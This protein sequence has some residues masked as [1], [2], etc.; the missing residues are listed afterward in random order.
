LHAFAIAVGLPDLPG[1]AL[2]A[3]VGEV[4]KQFGLD[5]ATAWAAG[6][7]SR[8]VLAAGV[9]HGSAAT[10]RRY[11][12]R[13]EQA[14]TLFD[15][16]PVEPSGRHV[17]HDAE[18]LAQG[19]DSWCADL[20]GQFCAAN[21]DLGRERVE[22]RLDTFGLMPIFSMRRGQGVLLSN[23]VQ[24]IR[25]LLDP[26]SLDALGVSTMLGLGWACD[27]HTLLEDVRVLAGGATYI[28]EPGRFQTRT[29][30]GPDAVDRQAGSRTTP[31][32]LTEFMARMIENAVG[33]VRPVHCAVTAGRDTR[34]LLAFMRSRGLDADFY[35]IGR[36]EDEDVLW[37]QE[38]GRRFGFEHRTIVPDQDTGLDWDSLAGD[39][40]AETDGLSNFGQLIDYTE[41]S[42]TPEQLGVKIWG[43]GSEIGRAGPGDTPIS[44]ANAPLLGSSLKLQRRI[45]EMKADGYRELMTAQ[46]QSILDRSIEEFAAQRLQEGW[47]VNEIAELFFT[48][49]RVACHGATGPRRAAAED[50][51]FSPFCSRRYAEYCLALKTTERYAELPYHQLL[52]RLSPE[53]YRYPFE[54]PL[55]SPRPWMTKPRAMERLTGVALKRFG[56]GTQGVDLQGGG[57]PPFVFEWFERSLDTMR[58]LFAQEQSPLWELI[59]RDRVLSLLG[60]SAEERYPHLEGL[61]R[62]ATVMWY[63]HGPGHS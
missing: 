41:L 14:L 12:S 39:F 9:H 56:F 49:E 30:F 40:L 52:S 19:W 6:S 21:I 20:E 28:L 31:D 62:A 27:H 4:G 59:E 54:T 36:S 8:S 33:D 60:A 53:L 63:F 11:L 47:K 17:G 26:S 42:G 2:V 45:L 44:A 43:I 3:A 34:L 58:E 37:A 25:A 10:P 1:E 24:V 18:Q 57:R 38:L 23:S 32:E 35:T 51:L 61:L 16:L 15:G 50:D 5:P 13:R 7:D 29:H 48:F 55:R 22:L 46:A